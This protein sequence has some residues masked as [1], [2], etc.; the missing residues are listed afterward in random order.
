MITIYQTLA[1]WLTDF[2][3]FDV[4]QNETAS[5]SFITLQLLFKLTKNENCDLS[6]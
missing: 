6:K 4:Q 2:I 5:E 3:L 1:I